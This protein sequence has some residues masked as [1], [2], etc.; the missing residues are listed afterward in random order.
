LFVPIGIKGY[1]G[2]LNTTLM[3]HLRTLR[4]LKKNT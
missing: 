2:L 4:T 3:H 1:S